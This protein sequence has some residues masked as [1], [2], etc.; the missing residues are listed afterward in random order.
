IADLPLDLLSSQQ[1]QLLVTAGL[2]LEK[3]TSNEK[4][5][6]LAPMLVA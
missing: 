6:V 5:V 1:K 4:V 2:S 3:H